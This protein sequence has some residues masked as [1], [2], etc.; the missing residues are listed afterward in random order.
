MS[1]GNYINVILPLRLGWEPVYRVPHETDP[2]S[3][4]TRV[5][6]CF[7]RGAYTGVVSELNVKTEID[8]SRIL[9]ISAVED[10]LPR[11]TPEEIRLWRF[12]AEYY[13]CSV[14]EVYKAAYPSARTDG[15]ETAAR[16]KERQ[17]GLEARRLAAEVAAIQKKKETLTLRLEKRKE[18]LARARKETVKER[19]EAEITDLES[20]LD[21]LESRLASRGMDKPVHDAAQ[22][23][24]QPPS[25]KEIT[26]NDAQATAYADICAAFHEGKPVLLH[27]ITGSGKTELYLKLAAKVLSEGRNVLYLVPEIALSRQLEDRLEAF[28]GPLLMT[29]HSART[30]SGKLKIADALR[31]HSERTPYVVLG[32][33]SAIFLP[34]HDLGLIIVDEEHDSSFKQSDPAPRYNARES[35]VVMAGIFNANIILG[36]A[37]PSL[38]SLYNCRT[39]KYALAKLDKRYYEGSGA[40]IEIIDT[41]AEKRKNGM[42]GSLSRK[43][44]ERISQTLENGGQVAI[45]RARR[46]YSPYVQCEKCGDIPKC[47][48]CNV[49]LSYHRD[50][51]RL[52]CHYCGRSRAFTGICPKCGGSL[53]TIGAGTQKIEEELTAAFPGISIARLDS[54]SARSTAYEKETL[55]G[56]ASGKI[57]ILVGTQI[58]TKGFDF[59]GLAL[60]AAIQADS[61]SAQDD[62]R[63]DERA[64]QLLE[65]FRG[66]SGRRGMKGLF[67]IQ[68]SQASH[69]VYKMLQGL[70]GDSIEKMMA[71]REAFGYPP[72][73]RIVNFVIKDYNEPRLD[74]MSSAL[75]RSISSEVKLQVTGPFAPAVD[76]ISNQHIRHIRV[77]VPKDKSQAWNKKQLKD[78]L[79]AFEKEKNYKDH[80]AIDVD[81]V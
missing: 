6:V 14:G 12:V 74:A 81:P 17:A 41:I 3:I 52:V 1:N 37:T 75:A 31:N 48:R 71:E 50:T 30:Q 62:F 60:V 7:G 63:A 2:V 61:L 69:P 44:L 4:G 15:E 49:T 8:P 26:L 64:L 34:H 47:P 78:V 13:M 11:V 35:A 25:F 22:D 23:I 39:G 68:T 70:D 58:V 79:E 10:N 65:Q 28:F 51:G 76:R 5:R 67:V 56:F 45:L 21:Q 20:E 57:K 55:E 72:Y 16:R 36:S 27:G 80:I 66:R 18:A 53:Q 43:L 24:Q 42:V 19:L 46:A 29:F 33:R 32:T 40:D 77:L 73:T 9:D 38:E 59:K 54:D